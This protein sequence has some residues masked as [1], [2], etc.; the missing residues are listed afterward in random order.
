LLVF[1]D[2]GLRSPLTMILFDNPPIEATVTIQKPVAAVFGFYRD[3]TN[4]PHFL[5]DVMAVDV[6]DATTTRWTIQGP[7]GIQ[8]HWSIKVTELRVNELICYETIT[9]PELRTRWE[10]HCSS[11]PTSGT[12]QVREVMHAPLGRSRPLGAVTSIA[13]GPMVHP[14]ASFPTNITSALASSTSPTI[15]SG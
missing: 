11:M 3:F 13:V 8:V 15:A 14:S 9:V 1:L 12:T 6:I 10:V 5:G 2:I 7:L 4:L